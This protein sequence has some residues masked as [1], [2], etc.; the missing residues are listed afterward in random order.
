[1]KGV[2][3]GLAIAKEIIVSHGGSIGVQSNPG[4]GSE[5]YFKLPTTN[6]GKK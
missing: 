5:F 1:L 4:Q 6:G 3:L 2:G